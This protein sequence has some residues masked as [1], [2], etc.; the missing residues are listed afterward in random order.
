A[1]PDLLTMTPDDLAGP[2]SDE[3]S[4]ADYPSTWGE[5]PLSYEFVP[6]EPDDGVAA[7]IPLASLNQVSADEFSW[8]V[9]GLREELVTELI[10]TLPKHLRT[11]FVPAPDVARDVLTRI[12]PHAGGHVRALDLELSRTGGVPVPAD[13]WD[14]ARLPA[15][16]RVTFRVVDDGQVLASGKDLDE[17]RADLR[18]A[19][20]ERLAAAAGELTRTGITAW[21]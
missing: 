21:D 20:Q 12:D 15:H 10:R 2:A 17:L 18:P 5:L 4:A 16:L 14:L 8:N 19:L 6:G 11:R 13:A 7:D 3:V 9:P 1:E